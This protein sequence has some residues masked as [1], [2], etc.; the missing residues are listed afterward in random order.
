MHP[1]HE[2]RNEK[3]YQKMKRFL[4]AKS[5]IY[6]HFLNLMCTN[7]FIST[8]FNNCV[9]INVNL[10]YSWHQNIII[11]IKTFAT[12]DFATTFRF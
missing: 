2:P 5:E 1:S 7:N 10:S 11:A 8:I 3:W 4:L 9:E 12:L 6:V